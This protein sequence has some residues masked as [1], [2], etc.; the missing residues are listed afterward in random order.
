MREEIKTRMLNCGKRTYFFDVKKATTGKLYLEITES[1]KT[2]DESRKRTTILVFPED[3]E[4]FRSILNDMV[5][6]IIKN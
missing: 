5:E 6:L 2:E 1:R 4:N 3:I